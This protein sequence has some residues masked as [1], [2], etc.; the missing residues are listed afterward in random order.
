MTFRLLASPMPTVRMV[1]PNQ[2][3][4]NGP[5]GSLKSISNRNRISP[6]PAPDA[7]RIPVRPASTPSAAYS[8]EKIC[9]I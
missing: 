2:S 6:H 1:T 3:P 9:P 8:V 5:A 4:T 7:S